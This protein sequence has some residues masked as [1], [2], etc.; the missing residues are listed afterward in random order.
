MKAA[1]HFIRI[2]SGA[3]IPAVF[4][5]GLG[6]Y[7]H[8]AKGADISPAAET[9]QDGALSADVRALLAP[10]AAKRVEGTFEERR[11]VPGFPTPMLSRGHFTLEGESL[12]WQTQTP[13]ASLMKVTP[14]GV[15][16]EAAGEKQALTAAEIP[17]VGR[18]CTLLTSVMG[19]RFD[20]LSDLFAVSAAQS[21]GRV[22]ISADPKSPELAQ[23]VKHIQAEAGSYLEKLTM[24]GPQGD[25]TVVLF[26]NVTVER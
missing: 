23:V 2:A 6:G 5:I 12:V 11:S 14:E 20:A 26:S 8:A 19:G 24:T 16:L 9:P 15:F 18:I 13:F 7:V 10:L 22:H 17:A 21:E 25:E 3:V 4:A 1:A